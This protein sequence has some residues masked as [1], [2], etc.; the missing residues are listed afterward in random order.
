MNAH[1]AEVSQ[2]A[3]VSL[4][5]GEDLPVHGQSHGVAA[6]GVH[7]HLLHHVVAEGSDLAGNGDGP[8]RQ[9]QAEPAIGG[10][11]AGVD[12]PLHRHYT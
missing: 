4:P 12:L 8:T 3:V 5:P 11:S 9:A 7:G 6:A 1:S 10:L 2:L